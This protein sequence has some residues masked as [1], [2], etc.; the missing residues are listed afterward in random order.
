MRTF[1][2]PNSKEYELFCSK[3]LSTVEKGDTIKKKQNVNNNMT[4]VEICKNLYG[5]SD[6][7][8]RKELYKNCTGSEFYIGSIN[9]NLKLK[10][11]TFPYLKTDVPY[12]IRV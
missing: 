12:K 6:F 11:Y 10:N 7:N 1:T 5:K 9:Q 3:D 2:R 8:F 4:L